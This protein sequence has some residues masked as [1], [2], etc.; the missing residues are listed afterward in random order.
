MRSQGFKDS[1]ET[2]KNK[3]DLMVKGANI[4]RSLL[5]AQARIAPQAGSTF[6]FDKRHL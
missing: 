6:H 2:P 3:K 4:L 5:L 1:S